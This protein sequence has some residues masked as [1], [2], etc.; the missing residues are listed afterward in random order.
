[1]A[2]IRYKE[3]KFAP[4]SWARIKI[5]NEIIKDF[6]AQGYTLTLRQLY[7]QFVAKDLIPNS[8]RSY[9][10]LGGLMTNA[11]MAGEVSW[12]ALEDR[13]R[14]HNSWSFEEEE[15]E[16]LAG[17]EYG[18]RWD[19]WARQDYYVEAWIEK[20]ALGDVLAK[21]CNPYRVPYM[22]CKGYM[23]S[24]AC[25]QGGQRFKAM[26]EAGKKC[27]LL[28]LGDHDPSGMDMTRDNGERVD[29]FAHYAGVEIRR[30]ALNMDQIDEHRP[31]P[32][33]AKVTDS[34]ARDY[35]E[36]YGSSSW[37]LDAL[38][39]AT[40]TG[41]I[42][43]ELKTLIKPDE[44]EACRADEENARKQLIKLRENWSEVSDYLDELPD[45]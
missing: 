14:T 21:A 6:R 16:A 40:I 34:R 42:H 26:E 11:R 1:M 22:S 23:S 31:P 25:W 44:W 29:M 7:Y 33:P 5:A 17:V 4:A 19:Y 20:E 43:D 18:L 35:I 15:T 2:F 13:S 10:S 41:L 39:P 30:L 45:D 28:H 38:N 36:R 8:E 9:N 32:N 12:Y 3:I 37:E 27:I 24:S